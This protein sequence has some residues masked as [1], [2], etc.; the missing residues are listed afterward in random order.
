MISLPH[1]VFGVLLSLS[2]LSGTSLLQAATATPPNAA[3]LYHNYCSVCHGDKGDGNSRGKEGMNPPPRDF[4]HPAARRELVRERIIASI[5]QG[6]PNTTMIG[7][8]AQLNEEEIAALADYL[9]NRFIQ[10]QA[11]IAKHPGKSLYEKNCAVCHGDKGDGGR[12]TSGMSVPP[13]DFTSERGRALG[14]EAMID[15]VSRGRPGTAMA[16]FAGQLQEQQIAE[17]VDYIRLAFMALPEEIEGL[18]GTYAHGRQTPPA[19]VSS[20]EP[21]AVD[22][23]APMPQGLSGN[24]DAGRD[25]YMGNCFTCHGT[26]GDG[27][28]PRAYFIRPKPANFFDAKYQQGFNRAALFTAIRDG[29][30][31]TEMPAWGK[32]LS[33]QQIADLAEFVFRAFIQGGGDGI[34]GAVEKKTP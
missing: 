24:P 27:Q 2:L 21:V 7:W 16:A 33:A 23:Q 1:T 28:G 25:F 19:P 10:P 14:R 6:R 5:S 4:T 11:G 17:V 32:V 9:L 20:P 15:A 22:M 3:L 31:G 18:S 30:L 29:K 12:W 34:V 26:A 8:S 13:R